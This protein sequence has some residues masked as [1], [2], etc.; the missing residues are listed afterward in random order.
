MSDECLC[1]SQSEVDVCVNLFKSKQFK[2]F[3]HTKPSSLK[4]YIANAKTQSNPIRLTESISHACQ[5]KFQSIQAVM[6][7]G[8]PEC[9]D[10]SDECRCDNPPRFC[11]DSYH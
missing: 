7:D 8:R 4:I 6:S 3:V 5:T 1:D 10:Y 2:Q 11:N 9:K